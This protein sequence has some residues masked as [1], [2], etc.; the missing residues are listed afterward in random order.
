M[1]REPANTKSVE[2]WE[3]ERGFLC[4]TYVNVPSMP[5]PERH[6]H[7]LE[8]GTREE[9]DREAQAYLDKDYASVNGETDAT[10]VGACE[11]YVKFS[12]GSGRF[13]PKTAYDYDADIKRYVKPYFRGMRLRDVST[14]TIADFYGRLYDK[15]LSP[16]TVS[17]VNN[18]LRGTFNHH[19]ETIHD[20]D[21][22]PMTSGLSPKPQDE[23]A[24]FLEREDAMKV[25]AFAD[26]CRA[27]PSCEPGKRIVSE[28]AA[29]ALRTG[30]RCGEVCGLQWRDFDPRASTVCV[31][32]TAYTVRG[33]TRTG[34]PKTK[35]GNRRIEVDARTLDA[36]KAFRAWQKDRGAP[37]GKSDFAFTLSGGVPRPGWISHR[38]SLLRGEIGI[39]ADTT[40]HTLRHTHASLLLSAGASPRAVSARLG[41]AK[42][43]ITMKIYAHVMTGDDGRLAAAME[44]AL[45]DEGGSDAS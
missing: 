22:S 10:V 20:L 29:L 39:P 15:G 18:L 43:E 38:F 7:R 45:D 28:A 30:M 17:Q 26:R 34:P 33:G 21:S 40:F 32:R 31:R 5:Q 44:R 35:A 37:V 24:P 23:D 16:R 14:Q 41:H 19:V 42:P 9:A 36:V 8:A 11:A 6:Q 27:E 1:A 2:V 12:Q 25:L 3:D 4:R 13:R